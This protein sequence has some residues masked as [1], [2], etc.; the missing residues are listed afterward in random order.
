MF[1]FVKKRLGTSV[2]EAIVNLFHSDLL[3]KKGLK[4]TD[5]VCKVISLPR[6]QEK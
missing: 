6:E 1:E 2:P 5:C 3:A 4:T